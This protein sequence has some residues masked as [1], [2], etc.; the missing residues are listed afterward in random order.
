MRTARGRLSAEPFLLIDN[1]ISR[2]ET[3]TTGSSIRR[4]DPVLVVFAMPRAHH[5]GHASI[6]DDAPRGARQ[7][8]V[9]GPAKIVPA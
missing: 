9:I 2:P 1:S 6:A 7:G 5:R 8:V 3:K 4:R